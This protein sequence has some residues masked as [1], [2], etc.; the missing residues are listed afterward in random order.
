MGYNNLQSLLQTLAAGGAP[1]TA[2]HRNIIDKLLK[3]ASI[4]T[5]ND[6]TA[7]IKGPCEPWELPVRC[8][9]CA[10]NAWQVEH[11]W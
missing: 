6:H 7:Q 9:A 10:I 5:R 11:E 3:G 1:S 8:Q 2:T 4:C